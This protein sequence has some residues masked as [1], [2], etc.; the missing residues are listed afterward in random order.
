MTKIWEVI[1]KNWKTTL[2][3]ILMF[4]AL[5]LW[6]AEVITADIFSIITTVLAGLGLVAAKDGN[7]TGV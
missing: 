2:G 6:Q 3:G 4:I 5:T 7:K 1:M